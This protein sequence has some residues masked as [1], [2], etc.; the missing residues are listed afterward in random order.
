MSR[1]VKGPSGRRYNVDRANAAGAARLARLEA[2][3]DFSSDPADRSMY[4]EKFP[5][6]A[7][8]DAWLEEC[9]PVDGA[10]EA[11]LEDGVVVPHV[12]AEP[13]VVVAEVDD[14][15]TAVPLHG[16]PAEV[17]SLLS[18]MVEAIDARAAYGPSEPTCPLEYRGP[19]CGYTGPLPTCAKTFEDCRRHERS[20][21]FAIPPMTDENLPL[22]RAWVA[23]QRPAS[24]PWGALVLRGMGQG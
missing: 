22:M 21:W 3:V 1:W 2:W 10:V 6:E 8:R 4:T 23:A 11:C 12:E 5:T 18:R 16:G 14:K 24:R 15:S 9:F 20:P 7:E 19:A 17:N 13:Y